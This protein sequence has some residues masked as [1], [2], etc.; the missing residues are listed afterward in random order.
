MVPVLILNYDCKCK[1][2][3][4]L[5]LFIKRSSFSNNV[6]TCF[7]TWYCQSPSARCCA[8]LKIHYLWTKTMF[9]HGSCKCLLIA[10]VYKLPQFH[11]TNRKNI[12]T[13]CVRILKILGNYV[14]TVDKKILTE[15]YLCRNV[16]KKIFQTFRPKFRSSDLKTLA[17][18]FL[19]IHQ[20]TEPPL[21][22][23]IFIFP[24]T[25]IQ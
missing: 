18:G 21:D 11:Y 24:C 20:N 19:C 10:I 5:F 4:Y 17:M 25:T 3:L 23:F 9:W 12:D 2:I 1:K 14:S 15:M 7:N 8:G 16:L 6:H 22:T 13:C